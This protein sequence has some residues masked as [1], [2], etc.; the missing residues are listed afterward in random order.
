MAH[1]F[2]HIW[3]VLMCIQMLSIRLNALPSQYMDNSDQYMSP[4]SRR[5]SMASHKQQGANLMKGI[6]PNDD[7]SSSLFMMDFKRQ[8]IMMHDP[9]EKTSSKLNVCPFSQVK[10][11]VIYET[12]IIDHSKIHRSWF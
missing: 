5:N 12:V 10:N 7:M 3:L 11:C 6:Q 8:A 2:L 4:Y 1:I 9:S